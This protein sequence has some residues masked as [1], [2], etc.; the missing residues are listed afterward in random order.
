MLVD[1]SLEVDA[2]EALI[3]EARRRTR[4]RRLG[5]AAGALAVAVIALAVLGFGHHWGVGQSGVRAAPS[6]LAP[7]SRLPAR[8]NG[9]LTVEVRRAGGVINADT[10]AAIKP[11]GSGLRPL[12]RCPGGCVFGPYV[13]SPDGKRLAFMSGHYGGATTV[14]KLWLYVVNADG[15][16]RRRLALCGVCLDRHIAWSPDSRQIAFATDAGLNVFDL[17]S[18]TERMLDIPG[19]AAPAWS[20]DGATIAF[21]NATQ[22]STI[23]PDGSHQRTFT[24][25]GDLVGDVSW[26]P[27][28]HSILFDAG[29]R[30]YTIGADGRNLRQLVSGPPNSGPGAPSWSPNG[31][32]ILYFSTP[33]AAGGYGAEVWTVKPNGSDRRRVYHTGCCEF[34]SSPI[35]SPDGKAIALGMSAFTTNGV[36]NNNGILVMDPRGKHRRRLLGN[37]MAFAWQ[38]ILRAR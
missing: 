35:W 9:V 14:S 20:P 4:L 32:R 38:P 21:G 23:R 26:S 31:R 29:D 17:G 16:D 36:F 7:I 5:Y 1:E 22:V 25:V 13:W 28:G 24:N 34:W 12:T 10:L 6:G 19:V 30:I 33:R 8:A 2:Q 3:E 27:D 11:D 18:G 15:S 37:P